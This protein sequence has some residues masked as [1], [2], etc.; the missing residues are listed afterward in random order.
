MDTYERGYGRRQLS[1]SPIRYRVTRARTIDPEMQ[2][3][4]L[5]YRDFVTI[6]AAR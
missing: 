1:R 2:L 4:A 5:Q 6:E 3:D